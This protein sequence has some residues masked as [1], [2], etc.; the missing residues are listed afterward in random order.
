[1]TLQVVSDPPGA[2]VLIDGKKQAL[3][4]PSLFKVERKDKLAVRVEKDGFRPYEE[5]VTVAADETEKAVVATLASTRVAGAQLRVRTNVKKATWKLDGQPVG[6][7]T[8]MLALKDL[9]PGQHQ[10]AVEAKGFDPKQEAVE[11]SPNGLAALD[12]TLTALTP[13]R[14]PG[15]GKTAASGKKP[16]RPASEEDVNSTSGW[17]PR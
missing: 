2:V 6:D 8:G 12:W 9:T 10:V 13:A 7:G 15:S 5:A 3:R 1:M 14:R 16:T 17:P 4:T 11:L